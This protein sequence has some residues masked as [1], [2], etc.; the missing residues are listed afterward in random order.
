MPKL[1][2]ASAPRVQG[3]AYPAPYAGDVA[4]RIVTKLGDAGGLTDFGVN[5]VELPPG[6]KS[7][8]RHWHTDED[9]FVMILTGVCDLVDDH[10]TQRLGP[11]DCASFPKNDGNGHHLINSSEASVTFLVV[12]TH[13]PKDTVYYSDIDMVAQCAGSNTRFETRDGAPLESTK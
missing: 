9:E 12:G 3:S 6:T 7:S 11:M 8:M 1:D 5:I 2:L 10:G 4:A 13:S